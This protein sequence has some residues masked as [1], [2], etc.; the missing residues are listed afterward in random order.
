MLIRTLATGVAGLAL[1]APLA[2][3]PSAAQADGDAPPF[4]LSMPA[5]V[6]AQSWDGDTFLGIGPRLVTGA[7]PFELRATRTA[8]TRPIVVKWRR[9]GGDVTLPDGTMTDF[10]GRPGFFR[11]SVR[12]PYGRLLHTSYVNLCPEGQTARVKPDA[13]AHNPYPMGCPWNPFTL[14]SVIGMQS[15]WYTEFGAWSGDSMR[16]R[17]GTYKLITT[18][19]PRYRDMF[20]ISGAQGRTESVL[21][22]VKGTDGGFRRARAALT[23]PAVPAAK[24]A[25][26]APSGAAATPDTG[27]KPDLRSLPA[28]GMQI[29]P[30]GNYLQFAATVWNG[31]DS[32][33]VVDGFRRSGE[34]L[35][36]AYQYFFDTAGNQVGYQPVGTMQWDP[37]PTHNHWHFTDFARYQ[38]LNQDKTLARRSEKEAFCLANTDA[39]DYTVPGADWHPDG[40]D[41]GTACG[42]YGSLSVRESLA[43]GSGDTYAQFRAGQSFDLKGLPNGIYWISVEANPEHNLVE[44]STANNVSL[45]KVRIGG[46]LGHRTVTYW[47][48]GLVDDSQWWGF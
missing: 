43:A 29:S 20:G 11:M 45:R 36:D 6:T 27:P 21:N 19:R 13:P 41:L 10:S 47:P 3:L 48:V 31:G 15:G 23:A 16:L 32:P 22:V 24:P 28:F 1:V 35:M 17:P 14:G 18:I 26:A 46:T 5:T 40:T 4:T 30:R 37:R 2:A 7:Q 25:P 39:V 12:G 38:L 8:Y 44:K 42:D 9:A 34:D 33:M